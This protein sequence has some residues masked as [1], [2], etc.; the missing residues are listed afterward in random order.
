LGKN[1][2]A[3]QGV[4]GKGSRNSWGDKKRPRGGN[5]GICNGGN[6]PVAEVKKG[7]R[8]YEKH[9]L[10][11]E[12]GNK[13]DTG[14]GTGARVTIKELQEEKKHMVGA[15]KKGEQKRSID[16]RSAKGQRNPGTRLI[17][18]RN[19]VKFKNEIRTRQEEGILT[20]PEGGTHPKNFV[21]HHIRKALGHR[22]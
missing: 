7:A 18:G 2:L 3:I 13:Q 16:R 4:V 12:S 14:S 6:R 8:K 15:K 21:E 22:I 9:R 19:E 10:T 1:I 5:L 17:G 20:K 11:W